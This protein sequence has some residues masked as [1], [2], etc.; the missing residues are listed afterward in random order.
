MIGAG[1][2]SGREIVAF[3]SVYGPLS[4][5]LCALSGAGMGALVG[6]GLR[7]S[8]PGD[9]LPGGSEGLGRAFLLAIFLAVA[10]AMTAAAGELAALT[11][12]LHNVRWIGSLFTLLLAMALS[13]RSMKVLPRLGK[14]LVPL[15]LMAWVLCALLP[16]KKTD[17]A[18][19]PSLW[20]GVKGGVFALCYGAM[21]VMLAVGPLCQAGKACTERQRKRVA[22][23]SGW[24]LGGLL[25]CG[26]AVFLY[27]GSDV[28]DQ[29]LPV[30]FLLRGYGKT[31]YDLS[32]ALLYLAVL[33]TL[34]PLFQGMEKLLWEK[35]GKYG[36]VTLGALCFLLSLA[37]FGPLVE[38]VY[39]ALGLICLIFFLFSK[40]RALTAP[41]KVSDGYCSSS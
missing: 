29:P 30:V 32:A 8:A 23:I 9:M 17:Q 13:R 4:W 1:F 2:A 14:V 19:L 33:T 27:H 18:L 38:R 7:L 16:G 41:E 25:L 12:P 28:L 35:A 15:L 10:G 21:N 20:E 26:N 24:M 34:I 3:F 36:Q 6:K 11:V 37:G 39:P 31:G 22:W 40:K 5:G